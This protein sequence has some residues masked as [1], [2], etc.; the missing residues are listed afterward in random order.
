MS[1]PLS[2]KRS[3]HARH[4]GEA[5]ALAAL[6]DYAEEGKNFFP[7]GLKSLPAFWP[8]IAVN[9]LR[10]ST[11]RDVTE[12][13]C[14]ITEARCREVLELAI[15]VVDKYLESELS[16]TEPK[17]IVDED[18]DGDCLKCGHPANNSSGHGTCDSRAHALKD[19]D[20]WL[21]R[22]LRSAQAEVA[23]WPEWK[24]KAMR[25]LPE[26]EDDELGEDEQ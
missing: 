8:S 6:R 1:Q 13:E 5:Y 3:E 23:S 21:E 9:G 26:P 22:S 16:D 7:K 2:K 11:S 25:V 24:K 12:A 4:V 14:N 19:D 15:K 17:E 10:T 18:E 20:N